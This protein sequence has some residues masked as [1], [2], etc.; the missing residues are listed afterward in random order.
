MK[1]IK[2]TTDYTLRWK[3][4]C[5]FSKDG[6][7]QDVSYITLQEPTYSNPENFY[8]IQD[9]VTAAQ[10]GMSKLIDS[11][12]IEELKEEDNTPGDAGGAEE[13]KFHEID[14]EEGLDE[15]IK[16]TLT[17]L[18]ATQNTPEFIKIFKKMT[19]K[20]RKRNPCL[21]DGEIPMTEAIMSTMHPLDFEGMAAK[22]V[23]FFILALEEPEKGSSVKASESATEVKEL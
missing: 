7:R 15:I 4:W 18:R 13:E 3:G 22:W 19:L 9:I 8:K 6:V 21:V 14:R 10:A 2:E 20:S 12:L 16:Q 1:A 17:S 11:S 23:S 5:K